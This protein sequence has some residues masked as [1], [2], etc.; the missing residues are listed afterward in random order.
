MVVYL[1]ILVLEKVFKVD[2]GVGIGSQPLSSIMEEKIKKPFIPTGTIAMSGS[3][4][5]STEDED[6]LVLSDAIDDFKSGKI[7]TI[8]GHAESWLTETAKAILDN[9]RRLGLIVLTFLDEYHQGLSGHWEDFRRE[10]KFVPGQLR[11]RTLKGAPCL[12]MTA[13]ST[14]SEITE[15]KTSLGLREDNTVILESSPIQSH[16]KFVRLQRPA[17]IYGTFG[18][19]TDLL[20]KPGLIHTLQKIYLDQ[21]IECVRQGLPVKKAM[22][23]FRKLEDL[24]NVYEFLCQELPEQAS[25]PY[26]CPFVQNHTSIGPITA[27]HMHSR[28]ND[29]SVFLTTSVMLMGLDLIDIDL[30]IMA[31]PFSMLHSVVQAAGRG[32]RNLGNK[33]RKNVLFY[34]LFNLSDIGRDVSVWA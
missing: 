21:Y 9:L 6:D 13:T 16:F 10:M 34:L 4:K 29:I 30:V 1:G 25:D 11:G 23:F 12:A 31:R 14:L 32:G 28:R 17:N 5:S 22:I 7:K 2:N 3:L 20:K 33:M 8:I 15:V 18:K 24:L 26:K 19:E 27:D